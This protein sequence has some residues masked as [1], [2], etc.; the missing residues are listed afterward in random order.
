[1]AYSLKHTFVTSDCHF[2][3]WQLSLSAFRAFSKD[4]EDELIANWNSVVEPNDI[5]IYN[6]DFC[7]CN[8]ISFCNYVKRLNGQIILVKGNHDM[9]P[10]E[11]YKA[12]FKDVVDKLV[13]DDLDLTIQHVPGEFSTKHQVFG[14]L[15][16]GQS[17]SN[18]PGFCSCIQANGLYPVSLERVLLSF[19]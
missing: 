19:K 18:I 9:L 2:G 3:S 15:H 7:D 10:D 11:L 14:H 1:M 17:T 4:E 5:V 16:R 6:G 12:A 8:A 13:L